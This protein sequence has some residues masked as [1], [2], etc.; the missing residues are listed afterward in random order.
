MSFGEHL[1]ARTRFFSAFSL[2]GVAQQLRI[3][4]TKLDCDAALRRNGALEFRLLRVNGVERVRSSTRA[5]AQSSDE[6]RPG[7]RNRNLVRGPLGIGKALSR[8]SGGG[9]TGAGPAP[10]MARAAP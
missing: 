10:A 8:G 5:F 7:L 3:V 9:A 4:K 1:G 6:Y 2:D